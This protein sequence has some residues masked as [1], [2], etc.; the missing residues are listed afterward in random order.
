MPQNGPLL[1]LPFRFT[2]K[3]SDECGGHSGSRDDAVCS[4]M[5]MASPAVSRARTCS[6]NSLLGEELLESSD[7]GGI[8]LQ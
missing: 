2:R 1:A 7:G 5:N 8:Q 6:N 3:I 4:F